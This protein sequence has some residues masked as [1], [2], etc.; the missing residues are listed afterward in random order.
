VAIVGPSGAGKSSL[1]GLLLGWHRP[2]GEGGVLRVDGAP[3][4]GDALEAL[5]RRTVWVD[6]TVYLW[7]RTLHQNL[8]YGLAAAPASLDEAIAGADLEEI[9]A[10]LPRGAESPLGEAGAL[11]SGGEGQRV[12]FGRGLTR[13]R[14]RLVILDEPF[15]G[16]VRERRHAL[17]ERAR[18]RWAGATLL[19]VTHDI[20]ETRAFPRVLVVAE[21]R[22]VEDGAPAEL[23]AR[24]GSRYA[25]LLEAETRVRR[26]AWTAAGTVA[27]RRLAMESGRVVAASEEPS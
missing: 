1:V 5:R 10:R 23:A 25:A 17:L 2:A 8:A 22:V 15:R 7:N 12:R 11:V 26:A 24:A 3:L 4:A 21:G 18:A 13:E 19:C 16:L 14:P 6:P 9:V 20:E 27:W